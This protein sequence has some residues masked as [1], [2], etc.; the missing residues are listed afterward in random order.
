[1]AQKYLIFISSTAEDLK[2]E[3]T[4]LAR[5][6]WELG[7]IPVMPDGFDPADP[8]AQRI[9]NRLIGD[10]D[11]FVSLAAHKYG[12]LP[13]GTSR[14]VGEYLMALKAEVPVLALI[15]DEK[16]RWK[17]TRKEQDEEAVKALEDFKVKLQSHPHI[18]WSTLPELENRARE[19]MLQEQFLNPRLGW[20]P[21]G[22][23]VHP[24]VI[25]EL[26]RLIIE[27]EKLKKY[28]FTE[29]ASPT[30]WQEKIKHTLE[31]L[32]VNNETLSF[33][34][35]AGN[36][37][38]NTIHSRYLRLIK[39]L[40][41]ELYTGKTTAELSRFLGSILNP[42]LSRAVRKDYPT[43]S[44]TIKKIMADFNLLN[45]VQFSGK[46][47]NEIWELTDFGK[48]LYAVYRLRQFERRIK[49]GNTKMIGNGEDEDG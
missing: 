28:S 21:G 33:F 30:Q 49:G 19:L 39:L 29:G 4:A 47:G 1:M 40:S 2:A 9:I 17:G 34:Y 43:P 16:A 24:Q 42:D 36:N 37:W 3:R 10:C 13:G 12:L 35:V 14:I 11:Y 6:I 26:G 41:P 31:V 15:I 23:A 20:E 5:I 46:E 8:T 48:E 18:F 7:H 44:N 27:N 45:L 32:A 22:G 25:N 38:E